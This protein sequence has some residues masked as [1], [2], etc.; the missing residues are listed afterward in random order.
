MRPGHPDSQH[1]VH[2]TEPVTILKLSA[3]TP[4]QTHPEKRQG[5]TAAP[6]GSFMSQSAVQLSLISKQKQH[7]ILFSKVK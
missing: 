5:A 6:R 3:E 4:N 7:Y 1:S 2:F